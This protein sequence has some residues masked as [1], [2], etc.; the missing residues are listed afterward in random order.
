MRNIRRQAQ[1]KGK[2]YCFLWPFFVLPQLLASAISKKEKQ[3]VRAGT[4]C[5]HSMNACNGKA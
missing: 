2:D 5:D 3:Q 1:N 4:L